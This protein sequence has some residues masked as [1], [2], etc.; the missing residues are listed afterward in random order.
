MQFVR[1]CVHKLSVH[2]HAQTGQLIT[3]EGIKMISVQRHK[4]KTPKVRRAWT[5][6]IHCKTAKTHL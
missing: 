2:F 4:L 5:D 6:V 3:S 1:Y